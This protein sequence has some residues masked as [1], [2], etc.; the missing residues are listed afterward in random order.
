VVAPRT[1]ER[2]GMSEAIQSKKPCPKCGSAKVYLLADDNIDSQWAWGWA[3]LNCWHKWPEQPAGPAMIAE[4]RKL[5]EAED[6]EVYPSAWK[7]SHVRLD[8]YMAWRIERQIGPNAATEYEWAT[9]PDG[10][11]WQHI[12][13]QAAISEAERLNA[14]ARP[15]GRRRA[16][17]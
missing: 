7:P 13:E 11:P 17:A 3:C 9:G 16:A 8:G 15:A 10:Q 5:A 12:E 1:H 2:G 4:P 14:G 6:G